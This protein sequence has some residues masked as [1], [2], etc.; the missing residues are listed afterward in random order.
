MSNTRFDLNSQNETI[1]DSRLLYVTA[2]RF[3]HDWHS[4]MH[5]HACAELFY[6]VRGL[7]QFT[8]STSQR[9]VGSDDLVIVNA[10][11]EHT[12]YSAES[13]PLEYI[14]LG[15]AGLEFQFDIPDGENSCAVI[16]CRDSR[17][18]ILFYLRELLRE[19]KEKLEQYDL[20]CHHLLQALLVKLLRTRHLKTSLS[21]TPVRRGSTECAA[22]RRYMDEHYFEPVTLDALA[23]FAHVNKYYLV[24][25]FS[26]EYG[27][28]PI[29][30]LIDRRIRES[31]YLLTNTNHSLSEIAQLLGFSSP[32]YFSQS[33]RRLCGQ[34]P[35]E[36]RKTQ[37][38]KIS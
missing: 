26:K 17:D 33:F 13:N 34:S 38:G 4:T 18:E 22:A 15:V 7:G 29:N 16:N 20:V 12:E 31:K 37:R 8:L 27:I 5:T 9:A 25:T 32:S 24:H 23:D 3:G 1:H 14:V 30:Y 19:S 2:S 28:T 35:M 10:N 36:Y 11:V 21:L 6:C